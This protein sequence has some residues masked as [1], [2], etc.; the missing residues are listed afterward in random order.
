M[1]REHARSVSRKTTI[2]GNAAM[3]ERRPNQPEDVSPEQ[4]AVH[5]TMG[6]LLGTL[7]ALF[8]VFS[9]ASRIHQLFWTSATPPAAIAMFVAMS[10]LTIAVGASL[11]GVIFSAIETERGVAD[12]KRRPPHGGT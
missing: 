7:G 5:F 2:D 3:P 6:A 10:A 9:H 12:A 11:T 8:L 1:E 4:V